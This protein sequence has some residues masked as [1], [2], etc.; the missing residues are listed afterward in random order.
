MN[1]I[2]YLTIYFIALFFC[3]TPCFAQLETIGKATVK[4]GVKSGLKTV[5]K[6][7]AKSTAKDIV[8]QNIKKKSI[9][10]GVKSTV[11]NQ[12]G[13]ELT[14]TTVKRV[15]KQA[16]KE[17]KNELIEKSIKI[18]GKK[19]LN[20][21]TKKLA[22]GI[23]G[24]SARNYLKDK[25][26]MFAINSGKKLS[27]NLVKNNLGKNLPLSKTIE[28]SIGKTGLNEVEKYLPDISS[29]QILV[30]D[31]LQK[32]QLAELFQKNPTLV[33]NYAQ[34]VN[35]KLRTDISKLRYLNYYADSYADACLFSKSKYLRASNLQ[36]IDD[37]QGNTI[38]KNAIT[39]E[40]LGLIVDDV[41]QITS[42]HSLLNM[43][44]MKNMKYKVDNSIFT[45]DKL[46]RPIEVKASISPKFKNTI[47][48]DRDKIVQRDFRKARTNASK[49]DSNKL[50]DDAGHLLAHDLG[51]VSD[52][53]NL[54]PQNRSLNRGDYKR[55]E[56][57]IKKDVKKGHSAEITI[58]INYKGASERPSS[59]TYEYKKDGNIVKSVIFDNRMEI[60][61]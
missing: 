16:I 53:I 55:M 34:C 4:T 30:D 57:L 56:N 58:K 46:G 38:I 9:K 27:D 60:S 41:I 42:N 8:I 26:K 45:T 31:L 15:S 54:V 23:I 51:G 19:A 44:L 18:A 6:K 33:K 5:V 32:P 14:E 47:I 29:K 11:T 39:G 61:N 3:I 52:G 24:K 7:Q 28:K 12:I 21:K 1:T 37:K 13:H 20:K 25:R 10:A 2:K 17:A 40:N 50:N 43:R 36:F 48:Y 35:S 49:L 22:N 59:Y